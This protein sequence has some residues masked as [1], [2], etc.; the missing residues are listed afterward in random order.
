MSKI[1]LKDLS[2]LKGNLKYDLSAGLVVFL[3]AVPLCLGIALASGAPLFSGLI[4]GIVGGLV[5]GSFSGSQL[6][7]SGP[8]A[9]LTIIVINAISTLG[10]FETFLCAVFI[11]GVL[12]VVMGYAKAGS[13]AAF[14]P[15]A[16]I[17][18][19][20][21][22]IGII[23][24]LKQIPHAVGYDMDYEGNLNF[25]QADDE[26]TISEIFKAF[27]AI[28]PGAV[29]ISLVSLIL[30]IYWGKIKWSVAQAIPAP[31]LVVV[32]GV[33]INS[34]FDSL[35]WADIVLGAEHLV[36][37]PVANSFNE[38]LSF[39]TIP[40]FSNFKNPQVYG[41]AITLALVATL[42]TLLNVEAV[43]K[44]DPYKRT[45]PK[46]RE[47]KA[48]GIGNMVS[49]LIGGLP[50]T[51]VI[52]RSSVAVNSGGRTKM[53]AI[54]HGFLILVAV[55]L[56][57]TMLNLIPLASLAAILLVTGYKLTTFALYK[58]FYKQGWDQFL[59][60]IVTVVA[61][62]FTDL[63]LGILIGMGV[64]IFFILRRNMKNNFSYQLEEQVDN[65]KVK[66]T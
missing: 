11:A 17:K 6:S 27:G 59:P 23:L 65:H 62:V 20:L 32:F 41:V 61:I 39:F 56:F 31:L 9:G 46:N 14:F 43:D 10:S 15:S 54:F 51:S 42:E 30:M 47:L 49:G 22:A 44:I 45:S 12:Q 34:L 55:V 57:P 36:Q 2:S 40:D 60:F 5:I 4:A 18:G 50:I 52:V 19:M 53:T 26:N 58:N 25:L 28:T 38:L 63:L 64:S 8:A 37:I 3:V 21:A 16:V 48:Q 33:V 35:G 66:I 1:N 29:V 13:I 7:V 24:I